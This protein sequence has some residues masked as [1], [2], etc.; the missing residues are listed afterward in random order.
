MVLF[1]FFGACWQPYMCIYHV[2]SCDKPCKAFF[3]SVPALIDDT[4]FSKCR[5]HDLMIC[6]K[7]Y[8]FLRYRFFCGL[9]FISLC[10]KTKTP[11][12]ISLI[13]PNLV[14]VESEWRSIYHLIEL[15]LHSYIHVF[16]M[17]VM[18][19]SGIELDFN[20][21]EWLVTLQDTQIC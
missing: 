1:P 12:Y 6:F 17:F 7:G 11:N 19:N 21:L 16:I 15:I 14:C 3:L 8:G 2:K 20:R 4:A 5:F 10:R 18:S 13:S 9:L